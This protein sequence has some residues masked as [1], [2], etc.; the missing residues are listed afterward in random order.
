[1]NMPTIAT[2][3]IRQPHKNYS[4]DE[5]GR[6]ITGNYI[7]KYIMADENNPPHGLRMHVKCAMECGWTIPQELQQQID[8]WEANNTTETDFMQKQGQPCLPGFEV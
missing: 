8:E 5:C 6:L 4:C 3:F 2:R 1:M 7:Y